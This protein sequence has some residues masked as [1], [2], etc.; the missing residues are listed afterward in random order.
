M[1]KMWWTKLML[2]LLIPGLLLTVGCAKKAVISDASMTQ[3]QMTDAEK[4]AAEKIKQA[5]AAEKR[6][7]EEE[8]L[9]AEKAQAAKWAR[10]K[11]MNNDIHFDYDKS[12]LTDMAQ[13]VLKK[14]AT[15]LMANPGLAVLIEGHCD[16]RGTN[17]YN[18]ALGERRA[19]SARTFLLDL[20]VPGDQMNTISFGEEKPVSMFDTEEG[21][22][23]NRRAHFEIE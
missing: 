16:E 23:L 6:A 7:I 17:E 4:Q 5:A 12:S 10:D 19:E 14:K 15:Y 13:E 21:W 9:V 18:L 1:R 22:A 2:V 20:G 11:F 8:Q 3:T